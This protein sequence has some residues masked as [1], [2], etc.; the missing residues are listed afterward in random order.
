MCGIS[1]CRLTSRCTLR[2]L[3]EYDARA[4][5]ELGLRSG[6]CIAS[7]CLEIMR[8]RSSIERLAGKPVTTETKV[9]AEKPRKCT[10]SFIV[11]IVDDAFIQNMRLLYWIKN[12][13]ASV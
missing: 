7:L 5:R 10:M 11:I 1:S 9:R 6:N 12:P 4:L 8:S 13:L 3:Q 2:K